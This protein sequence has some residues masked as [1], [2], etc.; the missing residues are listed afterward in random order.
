[1]LSKKGEEGD[2]EEIE[3]VQLIFV[4]LMGYVLWFFEKAL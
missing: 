1:V 2:R 4:L 3:E